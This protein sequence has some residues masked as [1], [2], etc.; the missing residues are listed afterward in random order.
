MIRR[1]MSGSAAAKRLGVSYPTMIKYAKKRLNIDYSKGFDEEDIKELGKILEKKGEHKA[2]KTEPQDNLTISQLARLVGTNQGTIRS[3]TTRHSLGQKK[4]VG[5]K[6][7]ILVFSREEIKQIQEK[8]QGHASKSL[9]ET[10]A[11][12]VSKSQFLVYV[13]GVRQLSGFSDV[14]KIKEFVQNSLITGQI[15][16][17]KKVPAKIEVKLEL[18]NLE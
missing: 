2:K 1:G 11:D 12:L 3:F 14:E 4:D 7:D 10:L 5:N 8:Y 13:P 17:Y 6:K 16:I 15:I 18:E 9:K